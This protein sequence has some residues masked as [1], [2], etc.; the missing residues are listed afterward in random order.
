MEN[1]LLQPLHPPFWQANELPNRVAI[2]ILSFSAR[3]PSTLK[4]LFAKLLQ[5]SD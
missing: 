5:C 2:R 1:S 3:N 4:T